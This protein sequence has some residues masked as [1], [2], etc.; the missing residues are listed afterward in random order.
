MLPSRLSAIAHRNRVLG[1]VDLS[2]ARQRIIAVVQDLSKDD[3]SGPVFRTGGLPFALVAGVIGE[4]LPDLS[5]VRFGFRNTSAVV[6]YCLHDSSF[7]L[8][9]RLGENPPQPWLIIEHEAPPGMTPLSVGEPRDTHSVD[10]YRELLGTGSPTI[11]SPARPD[12]ITVLAAAHSLSDDP[13]GLGQWID[14]TIQHLGGRLPRE[15]VKAGLLCM[16]SADVF[17]R[18]PLGAPLREQY[19]SLRQEYRSAETSLARIRHV[20]EERLEGVLGRVDEV[21]LDQI[22]PRSGETQAA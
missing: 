12:L 15:R 9:H 2:A 18:A 19:L 1:D 7:T 22:L 13:R 6:Q 17:A 14:D 10:F 20:S 4:A 21:L 11:K 3:E 5:P 16:V 8:A